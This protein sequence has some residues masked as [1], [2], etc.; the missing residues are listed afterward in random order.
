MSLPADWG[1]EDIVSPASPIGEDKQKDD[2]RS[3]GT[4]PDSEQSQTEPP[5]FIKATSLLTADS[6]T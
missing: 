3:A 1:E 6:N 2:K 5:K 4:P